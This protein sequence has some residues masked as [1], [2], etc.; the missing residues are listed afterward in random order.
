MLFDLR[1]DKVQVGSSETSLV[2]YYRDPVYINVEL[3]V[4]VRKVEW[5][6]DRLCRADFQ[7]G[8]FTDRNLWVCWNLFG[9]YVSYI[10]YYPWITI[11]AVWF[12]LLLKGSFDANK[13]FHKSY[14]AQELVS[15]KYFPVWCDLHN[16]N[17]LT[18]DA[19]ERTRV[20]VDR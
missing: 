10:L 13:Y 11:H 1:V 18:F 2:S 4:L 5:F 14:I 16:L 3:P 7:L 19:L 9:P 15:C 20:V 17:P 8:E 12:D 6:E